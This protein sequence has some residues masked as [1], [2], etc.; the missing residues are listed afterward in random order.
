MFL[1]QMKREVPDTGI[2]KSF[3]LFTWSSCYSG[4]DRQVGKGRSSQQCLSKADEEKP[5]QQGQEGGSFHQGRNIQ[6][7]A[8]GEVYV[9]FHS[10]K[11]SDLVQEQGCPWC[12]LLFPRWSQ[13]LAGCSQLDS[14][15]SICCHLLACSYWEAK[16]SSAVSSTPN[17]K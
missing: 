6:E 3:K 15:R 2:H 11:V 9:Y 10:C 7:V 12:P 8:N 14:V 1:N 16:A 4:F 13:S 17:W 5:E